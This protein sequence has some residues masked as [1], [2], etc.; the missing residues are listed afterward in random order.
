MA[1]NS[2]EVQLQKAIEMKGTVQEFAAIL[3]QR[4]NDLSDMLEHFVRAGFPSD[5]ARTYHARYYTP[6]NQIVSELSRKMLTEH[7]DFLDDV[8]ADLTIAKDRQ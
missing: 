5:I 8:I 6:D 7:V 3:T 4:M 1:T 2:V